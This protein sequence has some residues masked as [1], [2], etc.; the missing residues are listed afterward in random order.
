MTLQVTG[1][2][3][4]PVA[5][6][7]SVVLNVTAVDPTAEGHLTV[8]PAS[9]GPR[10]VASNVNFHPRRT[11][12]N[13][14][15]VKVGPTGAV[16][17]FN[18]AGLTDVVADVAGW[19]G[20]DAASGTRFTGVTPARIADTRNGTGVPAARLGQDRTLG[21]QVTGRGGVPATGVSAVVLNVTAVDPTAPEGYLTAWP[22]GLARPY[23]SNLNF[24]AGQTV[25]NVVVAK[26]GSG[27]IVNL[28][29]PAGLVDVVVDVAG[30]YGPEGASTGSGFTGV[31]PSRIVDTRNGNG[32]PLRPMDAGTSLAV[33]VT[34]R[35]GVPA[36]GVAA[37]ALNVTAVNPTATSY[38]TAWPAGVLR[39]LA[40]NLNLTAN[41][42]VP[43]MVFVK[44]GDG[45]VVNL[46]NAVGRTDVIVDV[47]G[48]YAA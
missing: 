20:K 32:A 2:G 18:A 23:A 44:V 26:V 38:L 10:P 47:A 6:V 1:H 3:G 7:S 25:P 24:Y 46:Y 43:N 41:R 34:G 45:G 39:P 29:N 12:A 27:G 4:V 31:L 37:V 28:Y 19:Y 17:L 5:G 22:A 11:V 21:I 42:T 13:L 8:W 36:T 35:G 14:A 33:Q 16:N 40:S 30:W 48:W 9:D 15:V